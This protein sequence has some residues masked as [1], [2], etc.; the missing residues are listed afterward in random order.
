[1]S[2]KQ[3]EYLYLVK[4]TAGDKIGTRRVILFKPATSWEQLEPVRQEIAEETKSDVSI[5]QIDW[6]STTEVEA[7]Q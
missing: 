1:M 7:A 2:T 5:Y 6:L 4:Y 3:Y